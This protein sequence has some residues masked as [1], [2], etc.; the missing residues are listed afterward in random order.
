MDEMSS[1]DALRWCEANR[2]VVDFSRAGVFV[3]CQNTTSF[4]PD[5]ISAVM[6]M[7]AKLE[8]RK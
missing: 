5:F 6:E 7:R 8:Q 3:S 4:G 1:L 2:A